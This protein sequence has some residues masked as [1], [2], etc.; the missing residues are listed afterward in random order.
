MKVLLSTVVKISPPRF[1]RTFSASKALTTMSQ[2]PITRRA[3]A[4]S[5]IALTALAVSS[6]AAFSAA[7]QW[8]DKK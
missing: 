6:F 2:H 3:F 7:D 4:L 5:S 8:K 1:F